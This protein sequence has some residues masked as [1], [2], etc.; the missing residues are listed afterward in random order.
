MS[1]VIV[2]RDPAQGRTATIIYVLYLIG[3]VIAVTHLIGVIVAY[4]Y[5]NDGPDW[6][7]TH[8]RF[9]I[10]TFWI[11]LLY[12]VIGFVM[13]HL[14]IGGLILF[15]TLIWFIVRCVKGLRRL[16]RGEAYDNVASWLW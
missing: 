6:V 7:R 4:V 1:Q 9:Q 10:R 14:L 8:Y 15:L 13:L 16:S 2:S 11:G 5:R 3:L 12:A